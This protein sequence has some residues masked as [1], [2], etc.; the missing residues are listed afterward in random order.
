MRN[1]VEA[2]IKRRMVWD[3]VPCALVTRVLTAVGA[4]PASEEILDHEH[5]ESHRRLNQL[6]P[7]DQTL[8][9]MCK[10]SAESIFHSIVETQSVAVSKEQIDVSVNQIRDVALS[11]TK[12]VIAG[13]IDDGLITVGRV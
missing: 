9:F 13:L 10:M 2:L 1:Q 7:I 3:T 5:K 12:A 4:S 11:A 6:A 8:Q